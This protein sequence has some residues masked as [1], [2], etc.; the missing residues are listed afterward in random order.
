MRGQRISTISAISTEGLIALDMKISS[1][2]DSDFLYDFI[3]GSLMSQMHPFD[4]SSPKSIVKMDNC[5]IHCVSKVK[6]L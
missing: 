5:S 1:S 4:G 2:V 6:Q 3:R